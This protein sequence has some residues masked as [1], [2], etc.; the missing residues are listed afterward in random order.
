LACEVESLYQGGRY[1][2]YKYRRYSDVRLAFAPEAAIGQ[3]GGD[4]DNFEFPRWALDMA[5]LR[6]Y[7]E[8]QPAAT[9]DYLTWRSE[10]PRAGEPVF[11]AGHPGSTERRL[12]VAELRFL[13]EV[14]LP[15]WL[16]R[17][18]ELR[19]R[20]LQFAQQ[21]AEAE[22]MAQNEI[23][24]L[25]NSIKLRRNQFA[26]LLDEAQMRRK[27]T[28]EQ[29][30]RE[31]VASDPELA[32][33]SY[34]WYQIEKAQQAFLPFRDEYIFNEGRAAL[35]GDLFRFARDLVRAAT[36]REKPNRD[37]LREY[38]DGALPRLEQRILADTPTPKRLESLQVAFGLAKMREYLGPDHPFVRKV[39]GNESPESM[40]TLLVDGTQ[41]DEVKFRRKL[42]QGGLSAIRASK[43]PMIRLARAV[44]GDARAV[45]LR[46][47]NEYEAPLAQAHER[48]AAAY[49]ALFGTDT[50]P[51][52]T[53]ALR[54]TFGTVAGW[55]ENGA[56]VDPFTTLERMYQRATGQPP[57]E[58]PARWLEAAGTLDPE[59]RVNFV[60]SLDMTGGNSGSPVVDADGRLVGLAFDGNRHSAAGAYWYDPALNRAVAVHPSI[61]WTALEAVYKAQY[62]HQELQNAAR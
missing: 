6:V 37:R 56:E 30:L 9:P 27:Q 45:R 47:E 8:E 18:I 20:Y 31:A 48:I 42:W 21:D 58:L 40:A 11:A 7:S 2:L 29:A 60:A 32:A 4:A 38:T 10:G 12:A 33:T 51:D 61:M 39:L 54:V 3:F 59:T 15:S 43:D 57:F 13:R 22:R 14:V 5:L 16:L 28:G 17:Y 1:F 49:F 41:L 26:A 19:G 50:Y 35:Q 23:A 44:D 34:A 25:E 53:F 55:T 36:E 62:L 24:S 46:Y 52:A